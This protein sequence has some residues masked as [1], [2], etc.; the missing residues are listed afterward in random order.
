M[1]LPDDIKA[2]I[3]AI[4]SQPGEVLSDAAVEE[5]A[6]NLLSFALHIG[7]EAR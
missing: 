7:A 2:E 4:F 3:R 5:I 6:N 1:T